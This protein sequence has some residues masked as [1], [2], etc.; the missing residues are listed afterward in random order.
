MLRDLSETAAG[1]VKGKPHL[2]LEQ[3]VQA[4]Y[5]D[6]VI[7]AANLR[8]TRMTEGRYALLRR[9]DRETLGTPQALDIDI[10]DHY[11]GMKR[12][13]GSLSGGESFQ[14]ALSMALGLSDIVQ[15][16]AGGVEIDALFID[17]G[18]GSLDSTSLQQALLALQE[19][20]GQR[21]FIGVISHVPDLKTQIERQIIVEKTAEGSALRL[22]L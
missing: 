11:T 18:F 17:E 6:Q 9:D 12:P 1:T 21:K 8:F 22:Q 7:E 10:L 4:F 13:V 14:A 20:S 2:S 16:H 3:Y 5:F 19:L 15:A